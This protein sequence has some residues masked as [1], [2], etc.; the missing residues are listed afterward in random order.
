[1][2][3]QIAK[4]RTFSDIFNAN[5]D[6]GSTFNSTF[7]MPYA[8]KDKKKKRNFSGAWTKRGW[9]PVFDPA[10]KNTMSSTVGGAGEMTMPAGSGD[11]AVAMGESRDAKFIGLLEALR[12]DVNSS[13]IDTIIEGFHL[14]HDDDD[15]SDL[16]HPDDIERA[17]YGE[18]EPE[19]DYSEYEPYVAKMADLIKSHGYWSDEVRNYND[20]I[21]RGFNVNR[22]HDMARG[23]TRTY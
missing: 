16:E 20:E 11:G 10:M 8:E 1:M 12:T 21:P 3:M 13:A 9:G 15:L 19:E 17:F 18:E 5:G 2:N 22:V 23:R 6:T 4:R 7:Q 14:L